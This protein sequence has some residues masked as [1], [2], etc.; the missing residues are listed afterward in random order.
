M[1]KGPVANTTG[2]LYVMRQVLDYLAVYK[3]NYLK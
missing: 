2:A 1:E 3:Q